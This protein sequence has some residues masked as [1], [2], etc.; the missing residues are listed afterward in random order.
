MA[1][2][3]DEVPKS[4]RQSLITAACVIWGFGL[5]FL[6]WWGLAEGEWKLEDLTIGPAALGI[7]LLTITIFR[8]LDPTKLTQKH[9]MKSR[10]MFIVGVI[11]I[12]RG[13]TFSS[14]V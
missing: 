12:L 7:L 10:R 3:Q 2:E 8:T 9:F 6:R 13:L 5:V 11:A 4:F 1:T 14:F